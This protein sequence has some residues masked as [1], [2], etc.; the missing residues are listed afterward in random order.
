MPYRQKLSAKAKIKRLGY[1]LFFSL[2]I[3]VL[4]A[5]LYLLVEPGS[6][7][8]GA[9]GPERTEISQAERSALMERSRELEARFRE[10][11]SGDE[12]P[13][14]EAIG[15]LKEAYASHRR[16]T[17]NNP[18][19]SLSDQRRLERLAEYVMEYEG[20]YLARRVEELQE[21]AEQKRSEGDYRAGIALLEEAGGIQ[22]HINR[23]MRRSPHSSTA[24]LSS[25]ERRIINWQAEP[26]VERS[27]EAEREAEQAVREERWAD[28]LE[29]FTEA[30]EGQQR[31]N[32]DFRRT[33]FLDRSRVSSLEEEIASL[34]TLELRAEITSLAEEGRQLLED[35]AFER[36]AERFAAASE[37]QRH[38]NREFSGSRYASS[39]AVREFETSRQT[40]LSG[41]VVKELNGVVEAMRQAFR[42]RRPD[43]ARRHL[44]GAQRKIRTLEEDFPLSEFIDEDLSL[45]ISYLHSIRDRLTAIHEDVYGYLTEIPGG[46][47]SL[48]A[49]EVPQSLYSRVMNRNPSRNQGSS[50]PVDSVNWE[51]A[52]EFCR[53]LSWVLGLPVR[54]PTRGEFLQAVGS[55]EET[56]I[57]GSSW[58]L[59]NSDGESQPVGTREPNRQGFYDLLGNVAEWLGTTEGDRR[60]FVAGG[61]YNDDLE[62]VREP[63]METVDT[64]QRSRA[65]GFRFVVERD[66]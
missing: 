40:A 10:S 1:V 17:V 56:D 60:A 64:G 57:S 28:A 49:V 50:L 45:R 53:R 22:E 13:D 62:E 66:G 30:K 38:L 39:G 43:E 46:E 63:P 51:E 23:E 42:E 54:L 35:E 61:S 4:G 26:I 9:R 6:G 16:A 15:I 7:P 32:E 37:R 27:R 47:V 34:R 48:Y 29:L 21:E 36:A 58:N 41:G 8:R 24:L 20:D 65:I 12:E 19:A 31:I 52:T 3:G 5:I 59:R 2:I 14:A 18:Y 55:L 44:E 25:L 33:P 11:V